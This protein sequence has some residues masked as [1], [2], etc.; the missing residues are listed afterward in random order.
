[1][2]GCFITGT[3]TEVGKTIVTAGLLR[4][5]VAR[6]RRA[7]AVKPFQTG[8]TIGDDGRLIPDDVLAYQRASQIDYATLP[9]ESVCRYRFEPACSPHLAAREAGL[10]C[11]A[12]EAVRAIGE[13]A[14]DFDVMLVEGAGGM[15]VPLGNS[16][17]MVDLARRLAMPIVVVVENR[18]GCINHA[19]MTVE[20]I[21]HASLDLAGIIMNNTSPASDDQERMIREENPRAIQR[22]GDCRILVELDYVD[23]FTIDDDRSWQPIADRLDVVAALF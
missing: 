10:E 16:E 9:P 5:L 18:L 4:A 22:F 3:G 1:M 2:Q 14:A 15:L 13:L 11:S 21:R 8:C 6:G 20:T 19:L 7:V 23:G 12:D 17:T